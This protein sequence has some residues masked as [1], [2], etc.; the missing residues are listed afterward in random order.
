MARSGRHAVSDPDVWPTRGSC[1]GTSCG[2]G[3][4]FPRAALPWILVAGSLALGACASHAPRRLVSAGATA[5][6][7]E[8]SI[9]ALSRKSVRREVAGRSVEKHPSFTLAFIEFDDQGRLWSPAQHDLL[10][11]TLRSEAQRAD[12]LAIVFF[13]HG[14]H[15]D[16][17]VCDSNVTCFRSYLAQ[18]AAGFDAAARL[19]GAGV[20]PPRVVGIYA[21]WRGRSFTVPVLR[22]LSFWSRKR[23]AERIGAGEL[24]EVLVHLDQFVRQLN[25]GD[26]DRAALYIIGHSFGGTMIYTALANVL[27]ARLVEALHRRERTPDADV[28]VD[29]FGNLVVLVNP[30]FEA[31]LYAPFEDLLARFRSFSKYQTPVLVVVGSETDVP[32][33]T[34]FRLG[35]GLA[36]LTQRTGPRSGRGSLTTAV[37]SWEPFTTHTLEAV[38]TTANGSPVDAPEC[39]C[40]Q[41]LTQLPPEEARRLGS[42]LSQLRQGELKASLGAFDRSACPD[43]LTLGSALLTSRPG[44]DSSRPIWHIR[45]SDDVVHGHSDF[46]TRPFLDFLRYVIVDAVSRKPS[47]R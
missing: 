40:R 27:K 43:G 44:V 38:G 35:R 7:V 8:T 9:D 39:A 34:W 10:D 17:G 15:H 20:S 36:V 32:N 25:S 5:E 6:S 28:V 30:A 1:A 31:S 19:A 37:G 11:R 41:P 3:A 26:R 42:F 22:N 4:R 29:G 46:F 47:R 23:A 24:I 14:W 33:R 45:A 18:L 12:A 21:G 13:A 16:A 2:E